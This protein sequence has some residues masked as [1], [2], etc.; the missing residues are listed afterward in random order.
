M[1]DGGR[2]PLPTLDAFKRVDCPK[3]G[4]QEAR[5]DTDTMDTF[6]ESSWYFERY[7]SPHCDTAMF[8]R[9]PE[10][11]ARLQQVLLPGEF[12]QCGRAHAVGKRPIAIFGR[13]ARKQIH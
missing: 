6:V 11:F 5:R 12:G 8:D 10:R 9:T 13:L 4:S 3:C 7:C 2:S 1:L